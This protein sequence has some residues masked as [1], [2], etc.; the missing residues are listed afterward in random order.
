[1]SE[2]KKIDTNF[3]H[4][5]M[6][7]LK[8][9]VLS[10][11]T[12]M[13]GM[14]LASCSSENDVIAPKPDTETVAPKE[15]TVSLGLK[16]EIVNITESPLATRA[17]EKND[18]YGI[19]VYSSPDKEGHY[20]GYTEYAYGLYDDVGKMTIKLLEGYKF[21]FVATMIVDGKNKVSFWD[22]GFYLPFHN[23]KTGYTRLS[24]AFK[25]SSVEYFDSYYLGNGY[26]YS[27][28]M[29][30]DVERPEHDRYYG[31]LEGYLPSE[32]GTATIDMKRT[33][34]GIKVIAAEMTEGKLTVKIDK[35]IDMN[36]VYPATEAQ[37]LL[38]FEYINSAWLTAFN[39]DNG[40]YGEAET[41]SDYSENIPISFTWTKDDGVELP[42]GT[43]T[44]EFKRNKLTTITIKVADK[45]MKGDIGV[46]YE[47]KGEMED[48]GTVEINPGG[49]SDNNVNP[50]P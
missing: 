39:A 2:I 3:K 21:K 22:N 11:L 35:S 8:F 49:S 5:C 28:I 25:Y 7:T 16:G 24:N 32:N 45:G 33:S 46:T 12:I 23:S 27:S 6:K 37:E 17:A 18:L 30:R 40:F 14:N 29:E 9:I 1:M 50:E 34:F 41:T 20:E 48:G 13:M 10:L 31:E 38:S 47:E 43:Q 4:T 19:Q 44:I 26:S 15:Y 42:L 36:I